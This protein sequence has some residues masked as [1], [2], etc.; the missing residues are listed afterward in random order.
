MRRE[1]VACALAG[2]VVSMILGCDQKQAT[3]EASPRPS[4]MSDK[5]IAWML[6]PIKEASWTALEDEV[7]DLQKEIRNPDT[8]GALFPIDT[9]YDTYQPL[10]LAWQVTKIK[11]SANPQGAVIHGQVMNRLVVLRQNVEF[12][13]ILADDKNNSLG[14]GEGV[15]ASAFPGVYTDFSALIR[16]QAPLATASQIVMAI[17]ERTGTTTPINLFT[18]Y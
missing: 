17:S 2:A 8:S 9:A 6:S 18:R 16:T 11:L 10:G 12:N 7:S 13:I 15:I 3:N 14:T 5:D 4:G 1:L